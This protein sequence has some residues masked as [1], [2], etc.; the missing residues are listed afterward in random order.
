MFQAVLFMLRSPTFLICIQ[1]LF[2]RMPDTHVLPGAL[3]P[4]LFCL[5]PG[6]L[7]K[8]KAIKTKVAQDVQLA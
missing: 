6:E 4:R 5:N 3:L 2:K 7:A 8:H 1:V